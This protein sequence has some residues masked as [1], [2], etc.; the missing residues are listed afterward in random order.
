MH[1]NLRNIIKASLFLCIKFIFVLWVLLTGLLVVFTPNLESLNNNSA[2]VST[3]EGTIL[4]I[5]RSS[6]D[7]IRLKTSP[8]D[9]DPLFLRMLQA[10]EDERFYMHP[11]V[12]PLS[13]TRALFSNLKNQRIVSGAST[14]AMQAVRSLKRPPR[15]L[16][17]KITEA[18]GALSL[19][20]FEGRDQVLTIWL[21]RAS[22]GAD[23]EGVKA[24]SLRYFGHLP[25]K[26]SPDEAALLVALPRAPEKLRPDRHPKEATYAIADV[27]R[28]CREKGV[29]S[30]SV[31][32]AV[33]SRDLPQKMHPWPQDQSGLCHRIFKQYPHQDIT[34][35]L[36][37][38]IQKIL[39]N[40]GRIF[41]QG[42]ISPITMAAVVLD[43]E[44]GVIVGLID[45]ASAQDSFMSLPYAIRSPGSTL[46]PF[47]YA[48]AF[49]QHLLHPQSILEDEKTFFGTWAPK[50]FSGTFLGKITAAK[51]LIYSLNLPALHVLQSIKPE[52]FTSRLTELGLKLPKGAPASV[53][54][55]LGGCGID[56]V[57]LS[58]LYAA[59]EDDGVWKPYLPF[60]DDAKVQKKNSQQR[61]LSAKA[62]RA[63]ATIL[64]E[65]PPPSGFTKILGLSY[66]TGTSR[67][68][69]DAFAIGSLGKYTVGV[70][71]GRADGKATDYLTGFKDAAPV[72]FEIMQA[73]SPTTFVKK[74]LG[75]NELLTNTAPEILADLSHNSAPNLDHQALH[76]EFPRTGDKLSPGLFGTIHLNIK[77]GV[78]PFYIAI[79]GR[80]C[81]ELD[82]DP[83]LYDI[84]HDG[85]MHIDVIDSKGQS[86]GIVI[87]VIND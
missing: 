22:F 77:G 69:R 59:L 53:A 49:E 74:D 79:N 20:L 16:K 58:A 83:K 73:L 30:S 70:W 21:T 76:I 51:A 34:L 14:L 6:D 75:Y 13:I 56:L 4:S 50:N 37:D 3:K 25:N 68:S 8:Q 15:S 2:S 38:P 40:Q 27:L 67:S 48:L 84:N 12:D 29:L 24:A 57:S 66:K 11:G 36:Q 60:K 1:K 45:A 28:L 31:S 17:A 61:I 39:K 82:F 9:L 71:C 32:D 85:I 46:K 55:I 35:T 26:L 78:P 19:T 23:I 72:L 87:S 43:R 52:N 63:T 47:A 7:K 86:D 33:I 80:A 41:R 18:L 54:V 81:D 44:Q 62:A 65:L 64:Q 5:E 10:S 42:H